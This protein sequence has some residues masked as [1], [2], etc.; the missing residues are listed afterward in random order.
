MKAYPSIQETPGPVDLAVLVIPSGA[1][2]S[3]MEQCV[4][5]GVKATI[6]ISGG[7]REVG[8]E[9]QVLERK[10][11]GI[12][13]GGGIRIV[14]PNCQGINNPHSNLCASWPLVTSKGSMGIIA[15]SGTIGAALLC[16]AQDEGIGVSK[17]ISLGNKADVNETELIEL[18]GEDVDT[19][20]IA[21]YIEGVT[22][23]QRFIDVCK[24]TA[25]RKP[26]LILKGGKTQLGS[27]AAMSHTRSLAG[28][29]EA[30]DAAFKRAGVIRVNELDE[31]YDGSKILSLSSPPPGNRVLILTSS[32]GAGILAADLCEEL[33]LELPPLPEE[34]KKQLRA[35]LP[36]QCILG[37]PIDL[38]GDTDAPRYETAVRLSEAS[39]PYDTY[40]LI[41]GDPIE[42]ATETVQ[43][44]R[45]DLKKPVIAC[46]V[47]GGETEK[48]ERGKMNSAEIPVFPTPERGIRAISAL[49]RYAKTM[50]R[51]G[52]G[53]P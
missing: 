19:K 22:D 32:G 14:G 6:I 43:A 28:R 39:S 40:Y 44:L 15:Q 16:W 18:L 11:V 51:R 42:K 7:F 41:F 33:G 4:R 46:Y 49:T 26:I 34:S 24:K 17:F 45:S 10:V 27:I 21:V 29:D 37:N 8:E 5:K 13:R 9:G 3:V 47:G 35:K 1:V 20:V 50:E 38:T 48:V 31:L 52:S 36:P 2:P 23:G 30:Y 25:V 53:S 12:A